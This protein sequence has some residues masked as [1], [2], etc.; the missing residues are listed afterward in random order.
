MEK[1]NGNSDKRGYQPSGSKG[2]FGYQ[3]S[4]GGGYTGITERYQPSGTQSGK[5]SKPPS[6]SSANDA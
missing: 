4:N 5:T 2:Q 6:G 3:P 1:G